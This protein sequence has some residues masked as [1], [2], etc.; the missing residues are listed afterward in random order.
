MTLV[1]LEYFQTTILYSQHISWLLSDR[2]IQVWV[3]YGAS[4]DALLNASPIMAG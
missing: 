4:L 1:M 3:I 2:C